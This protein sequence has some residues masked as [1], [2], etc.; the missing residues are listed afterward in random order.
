MPNPGA[1]YLSYIL[2]YERIWVDWLVDGW[3]SSGGTGADGC[4]IMASLQ[5]W[6]CTSLGASGHMNGVGLLQ[7]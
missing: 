1:M 4:E 7:R 3:H 5:G 6:N 2:K